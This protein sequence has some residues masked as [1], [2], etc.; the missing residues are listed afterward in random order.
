MCQALTNAL[1]IQVCVSVAICSLSIS[2]VL[3]AFARFMDF[4]RDTAMA[5]Y[6][7][8]LF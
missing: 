7:K 3:L 2:G 1:V 4:V 6:V 5:C 8:G